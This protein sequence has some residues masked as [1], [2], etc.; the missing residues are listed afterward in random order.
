[1]FDIQVQIYTISGKLL[2]TITTTQILDGNRSFP[3]SWDGLDDF[4][5]KIGK[6]VYMYRLR[7]RNQDQETAE[8]IEKL[9]IL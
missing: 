2:K 8:M 6:G 7:V 4:G 5:D 9:V 3:I 1:M